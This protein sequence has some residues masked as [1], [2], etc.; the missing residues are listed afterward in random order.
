MHM[1]LCRQRHPNGNAELSA[2]LKMHF[3]T[4]LPPISASSGDDEAW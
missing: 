1:V 2:Q 4:S 3:N